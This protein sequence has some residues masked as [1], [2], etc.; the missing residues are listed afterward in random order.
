V[1]FGAPDDPGLVVGGRSHRLC[2]VEF[3]I[4]K[5]SEPVQPVQH[6][7]RQTLFLDEDQVRPNNA[8]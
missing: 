1:I 3:R 8:N 7:F 2:F 4:L 5:G 6:G